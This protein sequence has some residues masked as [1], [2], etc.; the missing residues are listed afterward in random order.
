MR[1][2]WMGTK[3]PIYNCR[4]KWDSYPGKGRTEFL[5][6]AR[7]FCAYILDNLELLGQ[8]KRSWI[9][10]RASHPEWRKLGTELAL[11]EEIQAK[12]KLKRGGNNKSS[13]FWGK[14]N[15]FSLRH[16]KLLTSVQLFPGSLSVSL[17]GCP[18]VFLMIN[19]ITHHILCFQRAGDG[20]ENSLLIQSGW[21]LWTHQVVRCAE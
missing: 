16:S 12:I 8:E 19:H 15:K 3:P 6:P 5:A 13:I 11:G 9:S 18:C 20:G 17:S 14:C 7:F 4:P 10:G 1:R 21:W 2:G